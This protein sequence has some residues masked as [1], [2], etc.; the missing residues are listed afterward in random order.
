MII[1]PRS[2][3]ENLY[4]SLK[5]NNLSPSHIVS[6]MEP[7]GTSALIIMKLVNI[8]AN[9]AAKATI[10]KKLKA[11]DKIKL[12]SPCELFFRLEAFE[13]YLL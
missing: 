11:S 13:S 6:R 9:I 8:R 10:L 4:E 12:T 3:S 1:S 5:P 2:G 7:D